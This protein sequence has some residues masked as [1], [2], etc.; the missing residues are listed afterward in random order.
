MQA[1]ECSASAFAACA[2]PDIAE[3]LRPRYAD[4]GEW[5]SASQ[6]PVVYSPAYNIGFWGLENLHP[7]DSKKFQRV[8]AI[9]TE[10][11]VL[12]PGQLVAA[13]EATHDILREVHTE[14]YLRK[15]DS[16]S[17]EVAKV[18]AWPAEAWQFL[19]I[20]LSLA[21]LY[22]LSPDLADLPP[23]PTGDGAAPTALPAVLPAAEKSAAPN[24]D[25]GRRDHAGSGAGH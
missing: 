19:L 18:S 20:F 4:L 10:A 14:R 25:N 2:R 24:G 23:A 6:L 16:S 5:P 21:N 15:L 13:G 17:F 3:A 11:G 8:L 12:Q 9:L 1:Q 22:T 7:F